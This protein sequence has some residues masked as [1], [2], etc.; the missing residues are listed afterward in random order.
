MGKKQVV[1]NLS[2]SMGQKQAALKDYI[3]KDTTFYQYRSCLSKCKNCCF[4]RSNASVKPF[5]NLAKWTVKQVGKT[6]LGGNFRKASREPPVFCLCFLER[7]VVNKLPPCVIFEAIDTILITWI[8]MLGCLSLFI[9]I[10]SLI[11]K[12][13]LFQLVNFTLIPFCPISHSFC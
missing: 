1:A 2:S 6:N 9:S 7:N 8:W 11:Q 3:V 5:E 10:Y 13:L 12:Y 4:E